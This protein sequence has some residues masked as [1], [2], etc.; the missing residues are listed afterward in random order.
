MTRVGGVEA[1]LIGEIDMAEHVIG[2]V[3]D[4]I[5]VS[6]DALWEMDVPGNPE[7]DERLM[8]MRLRLQEMSTEL[9]DM[10]R[11]LL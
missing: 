10:R 6:L 3:A 8:T 11:S 5:T 7:R 9:S 2:H 4:A 1:L